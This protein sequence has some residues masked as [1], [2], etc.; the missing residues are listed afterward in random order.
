MAGLGAEL[1][2]AY[3]DTSGKVGKTKSKQRVLHVN[4]SPSKAQF[5]FSNLITL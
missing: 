3:P 2:R 5:I 1:S 4:F